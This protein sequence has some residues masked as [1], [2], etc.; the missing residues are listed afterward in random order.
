MRIARLLILFAALVALP[1]HAWAQDDDGWW[2]TLQ[3]LSGPGPFWGGGVDIGFICAEDTG[4]LHP[5]LFKGI[6]EGRNEFPSQVIALRFAFVSSGDR[7]RFED[8]TGD[9][10]PVHMLELGASY[11]YRF[12]R[13][14]DAGFAASWLRFSGDGFD[15][16]PR[17]AVTPVMVSFAPLATA[18]SEAWARIFRIRFEET[19]ITKGFNGA[20]FG[21]R[22]TAFS[23]DAELVRSV[24]FVA[25][26]GAL[27]SARR[28]RK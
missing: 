9:R 19:Y 18:S 27:L 12:H 2:G 14:F 13:A 21:S 3:R 6:P 17:F 22:T 20:D 24:K 28:D 8:T 1:S 5:C 4:P 10:R 11:K 15:S 26:L 23:T 16:F 7:E 25:D